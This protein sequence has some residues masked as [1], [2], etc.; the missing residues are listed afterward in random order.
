LQ[1]D[2]PAVI[3]GHRLTGRLASGGTS[4]VYL[5]R[6]PEGGHV[7]VKTIR[8]R[9]ADQAQARRWLRTE[10]ASSRRLPPFCTVRLL[11]DGSAE[12]PPYLIS[13]YVE[14]PSLAQYV[15]FLGPLE[16]DQLNA[17]AVALARAIAAVHGAGLIHCDLKPGNVLLAADGPRVIDFALAQPAPASGR[18]ARLGTVPYSPGWVAPERLNGHP[19]GPASDVFGWGCLIGY[20][21]TGPAIVAV[22]ATI[23]AVAGTGGAGPQAPVVPGSPPTADLAPP[24]DSQAPADPSRRSYGPRPASASSARHGSGS[25]AAGYRRQRAHTRPSTPTRP[26]GSHPPGSPPAPT[27]SPTHSPTPTHTSTPSPS[28]TTTGTGPAQGGGGTAAAPGAGN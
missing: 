5:A 13:E 4:T 22:L 8:A 2:D 27:H 9:Q 18:P 10:A 23:I 15:E 26:G 25:P 12:S 1:A 19:A 21:A 14:G 3:G 24:P 17:L 7:V 20:S 16:A 6:D 28:P 11:A